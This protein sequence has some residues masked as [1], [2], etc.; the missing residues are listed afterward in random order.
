MAAYYVVAEALA[1]T[2]KY[3]QATV[4]HVEVESRHGMLGVGV[5]DD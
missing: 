5:R 1:N 4:V 3:A 2:V